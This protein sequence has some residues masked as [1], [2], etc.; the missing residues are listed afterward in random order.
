MLTP[1]I[2]DGTIDFNEFVQMISSKMKLNDPDKELRNAFDVFDADR[3]GSITTE[4][5]RTA[6]ES[7]GE[8]LSEEDIDQMMAE[9]DEN[10]DGHVDF[11]GTI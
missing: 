10:R 11:A 9:A 6:V 3:D 4:E 8:H 2:G 5:L 7:L 1:P